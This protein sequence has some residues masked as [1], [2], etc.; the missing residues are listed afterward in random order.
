MEV[1]VDATQDPPGS[2]DWT[3]MLNDEVAEDG[4]FIWA[5]AERCRE[6]SVDEIVE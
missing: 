5:V 2:Q 3:H 4:G 1:F 6:I